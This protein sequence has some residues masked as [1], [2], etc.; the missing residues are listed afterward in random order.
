MWLVIS[1]TNN[2]LFHVGNL[3]LNCIKQYK[4]VPKLLRMDAGTEIM[5][6]QD[7]QVFIS[8]VKKKV[9]YMVAW[10]KKIENRGVLVKT[11]KV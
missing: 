8:L 5:Y 6:N 1:A 3:Y 4:T 7:L 2:D 9:F 10:Q 11:E